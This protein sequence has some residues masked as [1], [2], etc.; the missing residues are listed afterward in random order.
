[1]NFFIE[2]FSGPSDWSYQ[3]FSSG[4][5]QKDEGEESS[6]GGFENEI[7]SE[8]EKQSQ[9]KCIEEQERITNGVSQNLAFSF[10]KLLNTVRSSKLRSYIQRSLYNDSNFQ[11]FFR[12]VLMG[13]FKAHHR[14]KMNL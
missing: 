9:R 8:D 3:Q 10:S 1:M 14:L 5:T 12:D 11:A 7:S 4:F 2:L 6:F 13:C